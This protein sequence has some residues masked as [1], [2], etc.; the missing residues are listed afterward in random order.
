MIS[1]E[2]KKKPLPSWIFII[3]LMIFLQASC[4]SGSKERS[5]AQSDYADK[6]EIKVTLG[7]SQNLSDLNQEDVFYTITNH[8]DETVTKV[9][10][11]IVF[12]DM[13]GTEIGRDNILFLEESEKMEGVA[14]EGKK[15]RWQSLSPGQTMNDSYEL[16]YLLSGKPELREELK[17]V[18]DELTAS[19]E[20]KKI[21]TV[22]Y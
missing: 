16:L 2:R 8:G 19:T 9:Y 1:A 12:Y 11:E 20:I 4:S 3:A 18:W 17:E 14:A 22:A 15:A 21:E 13:D 10:G 6:I 7:P 5:S